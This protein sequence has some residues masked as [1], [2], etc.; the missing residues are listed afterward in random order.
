V[1]FTFDG[2]PLRAR[3]GEIITSALAAAGIHVYGRHA[4]DGSP[5]GLFCANGQCSQCLV[6]ADGVT[7]K[8]CVT[9]VSEG[10]VV[11]SLDGLPSLSERVTRTPSY[12]PTRQIETA[13]LVVGGGPAGC[14][15]AIEL[16]REQV[17]VLLV[18]DKQVLGGKLVLQTHMF[19]GS[20]EH[21]WAG[22]RGIDIARK[23]ADELS[24]LPSVEVMLDSSAVGVFWDRK[25]GVLTNGEYVLVEPQALLVAAG[26]R[27]KALAFPGCDLPGVF[28]AGAFQTLVNRDMVRPS[29]RLLI[30]GGGNVGLIAGYHALQAGIQVVGVVEALPQV[31]GYKVHADKLARLG[32]PLW[33]S[34]T[35]AAAHGRTRVEAATIVACDDS[36]RQIPGTERTYEADTIL[37]GVGLTPLDD[38]YRKA[39]AFGMRAYVA[40][41]AEEIA[42]A[43]AAIFGGRMVGRAVA[44]DLGRTVDTPSHWPHLQDVLKQKPGPQQPFVTKQLDQDVYPIIRCTQRIPCD[45]CVQACPV[46]A[47]RLDGDSVMDLPVYEGRCTGC[48]SC[49]ASCPGL[50]ITVVDLRE[51]SEG[52][53]RV[54]VPYE[55]PPEALEE[56]A[57]VACTGAEGAEVTSGTVVGIRIA[58]PWDRTALVTLR[59]TAEVAHEIA[60]IRTQEQAVSEPAPAPGG[61]GSP[62]VVVCRCERV[63]DEEIRQAVTD[64]VRDLNE[65][66]A[67]LRVGLGACGGRT[68]EEL[69][70]RIMAAEGV[71]CATITELTDRPP[72]VEIPLGVLAGRND[73]RDGLDTQP[74]PPEATGR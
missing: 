47:I 34:H 49:V 60:G 27:E 10:M 42:E 13:V 32:V 62:P 55:L 73:H 67:R 53:A 46:E 37:V 43:S 39:L 45:P 70:R 20:F 8:G 4:T 57:V 74:M 12:Q 66:K 69:V 25:V 7:V 63:T 56:G 30:V 6:V 64:G 61:R 19:F 41:D 51:R 52:Q 68:C 14:A 3:P 9:P 17:P 16:G 65:L 35:V 50:A 54:V 5:Q 31:G 2:T 72:N 36:F 24:A 1:S 28:G 23:L 15:A 59:V 26:A 58:R 33:T 21:V 18:D 29:S 40:G 38:L 22:T 11:C 71:D 48:L 44:R